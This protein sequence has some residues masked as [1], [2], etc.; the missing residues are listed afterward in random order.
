[1]AKIIKRNLKAKVFS[2]EDTILFNSLS[3]K[4]NLVRNKKPVIFISSPAKLFAQGEFIFI[5][6]STPPELSEQGRLLLNKD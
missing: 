2:S 3:A 5:N 4:S 1:M 6:S